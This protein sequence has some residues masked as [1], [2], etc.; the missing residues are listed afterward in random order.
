VTVNDLWVLGWIGGY[1]KLT[2]AHCVLFEHY[3][4]DIDT[5]RDAVLYV[6]DSTKDAP[7]F[8]VFQHTVGV[9]TIIRYLS[10]IQIPPRWIT[11]GPGGEGFVQAAD[12][13]IKSWIF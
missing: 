10:E 2:M 3:G 12:V 4:V 8:S 13:V 6:G 1:D 11:A 7:M 5:E 9:N